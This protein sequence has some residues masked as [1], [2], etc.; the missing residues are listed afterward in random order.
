MGKNIPTA[1]LDW[2]VD[3]VVQNKK[4]DETDYLYEHAGDYAQAARRRQI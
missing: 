3:L 1:N 4:L 2:L